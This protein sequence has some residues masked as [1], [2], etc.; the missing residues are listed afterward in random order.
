MSNQPDNVDKAVAYVFSEL[1]STYGAAWDKSLGQAPIADVKTKWAD[2]LEVY[3]HSE[4]AKKSIMWALKNLPDRVINSREFRTLCGHAPARVMP[5][6]PEPKAD[7]ARVAAELAKLGHVRV[8]TSSPHGMKDW[9]HRLKYRHEA[10]QKLS[11]Y[12]ISCYRDA[13]GASA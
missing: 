13:L 8:A 11:M 6:L 9:A 12:Q 7:P 1:A 10:G 4:E 2:A 3:L 5:A